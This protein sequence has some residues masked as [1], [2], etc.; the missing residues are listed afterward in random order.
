MIFSSIKICLHVCVEMFAK[1]HSIKLKSIG[2]V[3]QI[4]VTNSVE[5]GGTSMICHCNEEFSVLFR[6]V[7]SM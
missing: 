3:T 5:T 6:R 4:Q 2:S 7:H 1:E